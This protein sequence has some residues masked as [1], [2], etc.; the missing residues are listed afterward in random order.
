MHHQCTT[1]TMAVLLLALA[2]V[3]LT[4]ALNSQ[5][6]W[7]MYRY[8]VLKEAS[9]EFCNDA[10]TTN[11]NAAIDKTVFQFVDEPLSALWHETQL[12]VSFLIGNLKILL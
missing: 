3:A 1:V 4:T 12:R 11:C 10:Q 7:N 8:Q 5:D 6:I 9:R 2:M